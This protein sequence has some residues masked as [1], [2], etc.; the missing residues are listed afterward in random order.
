MTKNLNDILDR[1]EKLE[2]ISSK[3]EAL[4]SQSRKYEQS[5]RDLKMS[6]YYNRLKIIGG[7]VL[8][9]VVVLFLRYYIW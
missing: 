5:A 4:F 1:G 2:S 3:S 7:A 6:L 8:L 9:V